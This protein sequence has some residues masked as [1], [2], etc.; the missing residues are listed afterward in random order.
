MMGS[1]SSG[2]DKGDVSIPPGGGPGP[3]FP[4]RRIDG[5]RIAG[6]R[7]VA[8]GVAIASAVFARDGAPPP[9]ERL[10]NLEAELEDFLARSGTRARGMLSAMIWLVSIAGP[11][12]IGKFGTLGALA[13]PER[14]RAL[15]RLESGFGEPLVAVKAI[16]C[17]I[18]YEYPDAARDVGFDGKCLTAGSRG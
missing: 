12:F 7:T 17:L 16:L 3:A 14:I 11:L 18:Y 6:P 13:H 4:L 2:D 8:A 1:P 5:S 10:V 15:E 9:S